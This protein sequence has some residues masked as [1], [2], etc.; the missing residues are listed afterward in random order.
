M[1]GLVTLDASQLRR[2]STLIRNQEVLWINNIPFGSEWERVDYLRT[3]TLNF[4]TIG[5]LLDRADAVMDEFKFDRV[6]SP[7]ASDVYDQIIGLVTNALQAIPNY[8]VRKEFL[9]KVVPY[10]DEGVKLL[11]QVNPAD[12]AAVQALADDAET[13]KVAIKNFNATHGS[14]ASNQFAER[15]KAEGLDFEQ[16][17]FRLVKLS[18]YHVS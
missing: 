11:R 10:I 4:N 16:L 14:S 12:A 5:S 2:L 13:F 6:K 3:C 18:I 8:T 17:V 7:I 9:D 1:E 15:I